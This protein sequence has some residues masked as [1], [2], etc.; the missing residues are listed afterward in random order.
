LHPGDHLALAGYDLTFKSVDPA[1]QGPNYKA[2][3]GLFEVARD[4][5]LVTTLTPERREYVNPPMPISKVAIDTQW[6]SD[7]YLV[8]GAPDG[9]GGF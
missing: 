5:R 2:V 8:L 3:R 7:L 4:G 9:Q 1:F 6:F